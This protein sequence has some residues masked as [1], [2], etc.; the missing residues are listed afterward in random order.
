M[1]NKDFSCIV[2]PNFAIRQVVGNNNSD[3][4]MSF[5]AP[6]SKVP[7]QHCSSHHSNSIRHPFFIRFN[8]LYTHQLIH[9]P[10]IILLSFVFSKTPTNQPTIT[11]SDSDPDPSPSSSTVPTPSSPPSRRRNWYFIAIRV[12]LYEVAL[13]VLFGGVIYIWQAA[14][15]LSIFGSVLTRECTTDQA[16]N[17]IWRHI[18]VIWLSFAPASVLLASDLQRFAPFLYLH[19]A[20]H[21]GAG[22]ARLW[23]AWTW[24]IPGTPMGYFLVYITTFFDLSTPPF[25]LLLFALGK[26]AER[27]NRL[28][29]VTTGGSQAT[30]IDSSKKTN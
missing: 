13:V 2:T 5:C 14:N 9:S 16:L 29:M 28:L 6:S 11:M 24:G 20:T 4:T 17:N 22:L 30:D 7:T 3:R 19:A 23:T 15:A 10:P 12:I 25:V 21:F 1:L 18:S 8:P 26:R 27:K